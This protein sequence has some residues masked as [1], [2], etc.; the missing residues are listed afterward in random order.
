MKQI[1]LSIVIGSLVSFAAV[2][3]TEV[4]WI[5]GDAGS[6]KEPTNW[7]GGVI[8][9]GETVGN[10]IAVF[11]KSVDLTNT[12]YWYPAGIKISGAY[13]VTLDGGHLKAAGEL[14]N[15]ECVFDIAE[16]ATFE[17]KTS[18][19]G[20]EGATLVLRGGGLLRAMS[21]VGYDTLTSTYSKLRIES[22]EF[23]CP[24]SKGY[25]RFLDEVR[26]QDGGRFT[27]RVESAIESAPKT[28]LRP[29]VVV[30]EGGV[31]D[32]S[33]Y[34]QTLAAIS[35]D[36]TIDARSETANTGLIL[37]LAHSGY[38]FSGK[39]L[40]RLYVTPETG[41]TPA[42]SRIVIGDADTLAESILK[43]NTVSG[44][45]TDFRFAAGIGT[46]YVKELPTGTFYDT[47]GEPV[48]FDVKGASWYVD[49][50]REGDDPGDGLSRETAFKTLAAA[51]SNTALA[52]YDTVYVYPGVYSNGTMEVV[53]TSIATK[54]RAAVPANV[55]LVAVGSP[56]ETVILGED[57]PTPVADGLGDGPDAVRC[58]YLNAGA[59]VRGFTLTGGRV[60]STAK[61]T[62]DENRAQGGG[63]YAMGST[64]YVIGCVIS[65]CVAVRGGAAVAGSYI[66]CRFS[67]NFAFGLGGTW[68][69]EI[70][71]Y[72]CLVTDCRK[73]GSNLASVLWSNGK[74]GCFVNCTFGPGAGSIV[75]RGNTDATRFHVYNSIVLAETGTGNAG[76]ANVGTGTAFHNSILGRMT[77]TDLIV[78]DDC[79][80]A[81]LT[82]ASELLAFAGIG[83]DCVPLP[84]GASVDAG[85][86]S[87]YILPAKHL[88]DMRVDVFGN[89]RVSNG[90]LDRGAIERDARVDYAALLALDE[91]NAAALDVTAVSKSFSVA[92]GDPVALA[93]GEFLALDWADG[94]AAS[95][96]YSFVATVSGAGT[97]TVSNGTAE[98][99]VITAAESGQKTF[100]ASAGVSLTFV[101]TGEGSATLG[102]F[103]NTSYVKA[104]AEDGGLKVNGAA[105]GGVTAVPA[106]ET[107]MVTVTQCY[108]S[109]LP[110]IGFTVN[111]E[112]VAF[113]D[114]PDG[115]KGT[116]SG[117]DHATSLAIAAV[118]GEADG[119]YVDPVDGNDGNPGYHRNAAWK[120]LTYAMSKAQSGETVYLL[121]GEYGSETMMSGSRA[122]RVVVPAGVTLANADAIGSAVIVGGKA[123]VGLDDY[124][125]EIGS[126]AIA[127]ASL[128]AGS[129]LRGLTLRGGR[130]PNT[131]NGYAGGAYC[132]A[133]SV[134]EDCFVTNC[135]ARRGGAVWS[136]ICRRCRFY[137][138]NAAE[139]SAV[140][141]TTTFED[142]VFRNNGNIRQLNVTYNS[143]A[144]NCTFL[145]DVIKAQAGGWGSDQRVPGNM[146]NC[147]LW[148]AQANYPCYTHCA[149]VKGT[150]DFVSDGNM[151][152][153]SFRFDSAETGMGPD[154]ALTKDSMFVDAGILADDYSPIADA[155][156]SQRIYNGAIDIGACE[157]DWRGDFRREL[158]R[159]SCLTV[160]AATANVTTNALGGV[161]LPGD[162][163]SITATWTA[164]AGVKAT[165]SFQA[166]VA[167]EGVLVFTLNG[168]E[169]RRI[170]A[171]T[172]PVTVDFTSDLGTN[173]IELAFE[174]EG[175]AAVSSF[176]LNSKGLILLVR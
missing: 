43:I 138:N 51:L 44:C 145:P 84:D 108:D 20:Y 31:F 12:G 171:T 120:T 53:Q 32:C 129:V 65:N 36:G 118:Y 102:A 154:G 111:G 123:T 119:W 168:E 40:G 135:A 47:D 17:V 59:S 90:V 124:G 49:C 148:C 173:V 57:S 33:G 60:Y 116:V 88:S 7:E 26:I 105:A 126:D 11:E 133:S 18:L 13:T 89:P 73:V 104:E 156:Q 161:L 2:A 83:A 137:S 174:G 170:A 103:A 122:F 5:G 160:D 71:A 106:G 14:D 69:E 98:A 166:E 147:V 61:N 41:V 172:A 117:D 27:C 127:C 176:K 132:V 86:D 68:Y 146:V 153:G 150:A 28:G 63:V 136:G 35:G 134:V 91:V 42:D 24:R 157:Y 58:V 15:D 45:T 121:A 62:P 109:A 9:S 25:T 97:L 159:K 38:T 107:L 54:N 140:G 115:W 79:L 175:E 6:V 151:G 10:Y 125:L 85:K 149:F 46:F 164:E 75:G 131:S 30:E 74:T 70:R 96:L 66:G 113:A 155:W 21:A 22:G 52:A 152:E 78:D 114:W 128:G 112:Y 163:E 162:G 8:P 50:R 56:E 34:K 95:T 39:I 55:K 139:M 94:G 142:C 82:A 48:E 23:Q 1:C 80:V 100:S 101:F 67:D 3:A 144:R 158:T 169:V 77:G 64:C 37:N 110:C 130:S 19:Q 93:D 16:G 165:G 92:P 72:N 167:G 141:E 29:V 4:K 87:C 143:K 99:Y 81:N 76:E